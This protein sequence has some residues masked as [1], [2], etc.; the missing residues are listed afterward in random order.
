MTPPQNLTGIVVDTYEQFRRWC[1]DN[2]RNPRD[3]SLRMIQDVRH[4][5]GYWFDQIIELGG[6]SYLLSLAKSRHRPAPANK[7]A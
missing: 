7:E 4:A 2:N 1:Y 3:P 5:Q 6:N